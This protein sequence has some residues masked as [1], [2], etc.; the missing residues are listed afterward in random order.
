MQCPDCG[1]DSKVIST[2][3]KGVAT[4][5]A[6]TC[7]SGHVNIVAEIAEQATAGELEATLI[8]VAGIPGP[9][10]RLVQKYAIPTIE[11]AIRVATTPA[12]VKGN[13]SKRRLDLWERKFLEERLSDP[14]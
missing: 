5:V 9:E 13:L 4:L 6:L 10:R 8:D 7:T 12:S 2:Q 3:I 1:C 11:A 14:Y